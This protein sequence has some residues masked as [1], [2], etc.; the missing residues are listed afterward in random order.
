[1]WK[2]LSKMPFKG[3]TIKK[4]V[5]Q[6]YRFRVIYSLNREETHSKTTVPATTA[7]EAAQFVRQRF[8]PAKVT[9]HD[10]RLVSEEE[11]TTLTLKDEA[12]AFTARNN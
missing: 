2:V 12:N 1:M 4:W 8:A 11:N 6:K 10:I 5:T 7:N 3:D 9:I